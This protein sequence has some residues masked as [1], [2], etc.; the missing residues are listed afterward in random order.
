[1]KYYLIA[2]TIGWAVGLAIS[3]L[4]CT[5]LGDVPASKPVTR[6]TTELKKEVV[7]SELSYSKAVDSLKK[8]SIKLQS[9][10]STTKTE[11]SKTKQKNYSLQLTIYD[12]IN[13]QSEN[14]QKGNVPANNDCDSLIVTVE[15]LMQSSSEKDSLYEKTTINL[16][17]QLKIKDSTITVKDKQYTEIKS[18]FTK[19]VESTNELSSQNLQ[20]AKQVKR[21]K[22]KTK[23]WSAAFFILTGAAVNY[24]IHH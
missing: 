5:M 2:F 19:T 6:V 7:K 22:F 14:K 11:L 24:L 12:L 1:M 4:Y 18:A 16:E 23:I 15:Q 3:F 17:D 9:E 8:Q 20:L 13:R 10:L 21:Q